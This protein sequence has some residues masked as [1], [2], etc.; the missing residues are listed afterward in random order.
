MTFSKASRLSLYSYSLY[1]SVGSRI[2]Y[3]L[4][5]LLALPFFFWGVSGLFS[6]NFTQYDLYGLSIV[7]SITAT[8]LITMELRKSFMDYKGKLIL[9]ASWINIIG[10]LIGLFIFLTYSTNSGFGVDIRNLVYGFL[11]ALS[12]QIISCI[13]NF[14]GVRRSP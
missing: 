5:A 6:Y 3:V 11:F 8:L 9:M 7:S 1:I 2:I 13:V 4:S 10:F 14:I 12:A